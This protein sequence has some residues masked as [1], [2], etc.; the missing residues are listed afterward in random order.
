MVSAYL[1]AQGIYPVPG[2]EQ[3]DD[4]LF[5]CA[6]PED[7]HIVL[8]ESANGLIELADLLVSLAL[9]GENIGHHWHVDTTNLLSDR[10]EIQGMILRRN[11]VQ[12]SAKEQ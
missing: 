8:S 11:S 3:E 6:Q 10:S 9:S 5:L 1:A 7:S 4:E 2:T 12:E